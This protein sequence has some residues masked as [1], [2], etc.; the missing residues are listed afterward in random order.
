M[1]ADPPASAEKDFSMPAAPTVSVVIA[2]HE[3]PAALERLLLEIKEQSLTDFEVIVADDNS[4]EQVREGYAALWARL[5]ARFKLHFV[6]PGISRKSPG[7]TR[8]YG[9]EQASG[10]FIAFCDDDDRWI[11]PDHLQTA[12][13]AMRSQDAD[14]FLANMQT[15][16]GGE[17]L[18]P[19][20]YE[21]SWRHLKRHGRG[22]AGAGDLFVVDRDMFA[23]FF[24]GRTPHVNT[25]VMT[26]A[27]FDA[28]GPFW[29]QIVFAEDH[30][31]MFRV[32]DRARKSL[33]RSTVVADL[34]VGEHASVARA[35]EQDERRL[36]SI[37]AC[38]H[39]ATL[40]SHPALRRR[41]R[42]DRA[43]R[44]LE[45]ARSQMA[46]GRIACAREFAA[47]SLRTQPSRSAL[48]LALRLL[49]MRA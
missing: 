44:L 20:Y 19:D 32:F 25:L 12:V 29:R 41:L 21:R 33:F 26:R 3:R 5:D 4:S 45:I 11:R 8:N 10:Q 40:I 9:V 31:W 6:P 15:S 36:F 18:N 38:F 17:R 35:F 1:A 49:L 46:Q 16:V 22:I 27:L 39:A 43:G 2:T 37:L 34:D 48:A 14:L 28:A 13:T 47:E 23:G 7:V 42:C 30:D 24:W